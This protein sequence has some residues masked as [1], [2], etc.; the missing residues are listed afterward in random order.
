MFSETEWKQDE[1]E[2]RSIRKMK[3]KKK[4]KPWDLD[5]Q[6]FRLT[7]SDHRTLTIP[8]LWLIWSL[9]NA[10]ARHQN[11][12][13]RHQTQFLYWQL[14]L[15]VLPSQVGKRFA[16]ICKTEPFKNYMTIH[17]QT[18]S[19]RA[20]VKATSQ[21]LCT[22][23]WDRHQSSE[24]L[25]QTSDK[26][27]P[28]KFAHQQTFTLKYGPKTHPT[29]KR[30]EVCFDSYVQLQWGTDVMMCYTHEKNYWKSYKDPI[31]FWVPSA[32]CGSLLCSPAKCE[33][34]QEKHST[35]SLR[36]KIRFPFQQICSWR[37]RTDWT[38]EK[39][40]HTL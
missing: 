18:H 21:N 22:N 11:T 10:P 4:L 12:H 23:N 8:A 33:P 25:T 6:T 36:Q 14:R 16:N 39:F 26:R 9:T 19:S 37:S 20:I 17:L 1:Y 5:L 7:S 32:W 13:K 31:H 40:P 27:I 2:S 28:T 24:R 38:L 34:N 3:D 15:R 30:D 35:R 29:P